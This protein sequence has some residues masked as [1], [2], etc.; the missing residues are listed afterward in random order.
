MIRRLIS[1]NIKLVFKLENKTVKI[2]ADSSQIE[3]IIINLI[4]NARDAINAK[5]SAFKKR[6]IVLTTGYKNIDDSF[7]RKYPGTSCGQYALISVEDSGIG[8]DEKTKQRVFEPFFTT[9]AVDKGTGLGLSTVYGIVKQNGGCLYVESEPGKGSRFNILWP[10]ARDG[11]KIIQTVESEHTTSNPA[12]TETIL[13]VEDDENVRSF[14]CE[15]LKEMNYKVICASNG[16]EALKKT[17]SGKSKV[18]LLITDI[19]MP[20]MDGKELVSKMS[21]RIDLNRVLF[22]SGYPFDNL[23]KEG[24]LEKGIHFLQ[25]PYSVHSLNTKIRSILDSLV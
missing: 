5:K 4:V 3:Q 17:S 2:K 12:G 15:A 18:D 9:K 25:K 19:V 22:V 13:L 11:E 10:L 24:S 7:V 16:M 8:M 21:G 20:G 1:E 6:Q 14:A 23:V